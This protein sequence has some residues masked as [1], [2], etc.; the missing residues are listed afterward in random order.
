MRIEKI[1]VGTAMVLCLT[2]APLDAAS[3]GKGRPPVKTTPAPN[4]N[5]SS[6]IAIA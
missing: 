4:L 2:L 5:N 1:T 3:K 6:T